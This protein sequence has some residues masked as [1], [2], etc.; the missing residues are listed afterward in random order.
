MLSDRHMKISAPGRI[1]YF[2][3][4]LFYLKKISQCVFY[5][6]L[7]IV[8]STNLKKKGRSCP[9]PISY[10]GS[11]NN[12]ATTAQFSAILAG[13]VSLAQECIVQVSIGH[14]NIGQV[15]IGQVRADDFGIVHFSTV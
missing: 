1:Q 3:A 9:F 8:V 10:S 14:V 15:S 5:L 6:I 2:C 4:I 12:C 7:Y 11:I 13:K